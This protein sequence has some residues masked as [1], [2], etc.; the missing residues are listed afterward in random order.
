MGPSA[1]GIQMGQKLDQL[2]VLEAEGSGR[3][4]IMPPEPYPGFES[5]KVDVAPNSGVFWLMAIGNNHEDDG[6]GES[7]RVAY[8]K[9]QRILETKYGQYEMSDTVP[10]NTR[11][12]EWVMAICNGSEFGSQWHEEY[13]SSL[14]EGLNSIV[15]TIGAFEASTSYVIIHYCFS[16]S[17]IGQKEI[18]LASPL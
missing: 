5:Y 15:L 6:S 9:L 8:R 10:G 1:F 7:V 12:R 14:P 11:P 2:D 3:Y 16:N 4:K 17:S 18:D 13:G